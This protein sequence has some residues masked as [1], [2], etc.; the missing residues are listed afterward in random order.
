MADILK[1]PHLIVA[2]GGRVH[3]DKTESVESADLVLGDKELLES[4]NFLG[5][6]NN[7][8]SGAGPAGSKRSVGS[9]DVGGR[10]ETV[11]V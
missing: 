4:D 3:L 5:G 11:V 1:D 7:V 6:D 8:V 2:W 10:D 9:R